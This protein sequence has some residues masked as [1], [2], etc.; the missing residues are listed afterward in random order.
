MPRTTHGNG[1]G[2]FAP[3]DDTWRTP[4]GVGRCG[5]DPDPE[6]VAVRQLPDG[7]VRVANSGT[8][9]H[10]VEFT[11]AEWETFVTGVKAD[12]FNVA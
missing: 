12:Q 8:C 5:P 10:F 6:C 3:L 2:G 7:T 4:H 9:G 11:S 1:G